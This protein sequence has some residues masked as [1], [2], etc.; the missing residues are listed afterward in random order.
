M[1]NPATLSKDGARNAYFLHCRLHG[2]QRP[3]AVCLHHADRV[4]AGKTSQLYTDCDRAI[5]SG[6]CQALGMHREELEKGQPIYFI[7][8]QK[9]PLSAPA[10]SMTITT[11]EYT[12]SG[13]VELRKHVL[14]ALP[15]PAPR[16]PVE[17]GYAAAINAAL[18][19]Q[20]EEIAQVSPAAAAPATPVVATPKPPA[21]PGES[22]LAYARRIKALQEGNT[23]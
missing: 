16:A 17:G 8:R 1:S 20:R 6:T 10:D 23:A 5:D 14:V 12:E 19:E 18:K 11:T 3:Y 22:P 9:Q 4:A 13:E 7:E 2:Q 21:L 15:N